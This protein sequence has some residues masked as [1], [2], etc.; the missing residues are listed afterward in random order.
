VALDQVD[1][2]PIG[3]QKPAP[4]YTALARTRRQ[5]GTVV[6]DILVDETGHVADVRLV[7]GIPGSDLDAVAMSAV[8]S[9]VYKPAE[10]DGVPVR[11]W[12]PEQIRFKL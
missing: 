7:R 6:M 8:R 9:W 1:S 10:K 11:V 3:L 4:Q 2:P 5:E 12:R